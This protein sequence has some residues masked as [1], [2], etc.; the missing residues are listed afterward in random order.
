MHGMGAPKDLVGSRAGES[1]IGDEA[2][3][4]LGVGQQIEEPETDRVPRRLVACGR[5]RVEAFDLL[6]TQSDWSV[7]DPGRPSF[8]S[9]R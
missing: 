6:D 5:E 9:R 1:G 2:R 4:L 8:V 7:A 3:L